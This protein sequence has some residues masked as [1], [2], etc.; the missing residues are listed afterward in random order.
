MNED[1]ALTL[2]LRLVHSV[3]YWAAEP[4]WHRRLLCAC[5]SH[6]CKTFLRF[7]RTWTHVRYMLSPVRLS[8]VCRR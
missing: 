5:I 4:F 6:R 2:S 1:V 8:S 3:V 7:K